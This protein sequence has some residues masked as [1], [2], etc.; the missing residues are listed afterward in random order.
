MTSNGFLEANNKKTI[1]KI[2]TL[3]LSVARERKKDR[4]RVIP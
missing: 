3:R 4:E 1:A 2:K